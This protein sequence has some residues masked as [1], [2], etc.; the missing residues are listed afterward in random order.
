[1]LTTTENRLAGDGG[2]RVAESGETTLSLDGKQVTVASAEI[3]SGPR[4]QL[5]WSFYIVDGKITARLIEAKLLQARAVLLRR[6]PV[7][8]L[9]AF[10]AS[11]NDPGDPAEGQLARFL[12]AS[13]SLPR[14]VDSL[15]S[16]KT[17]PGV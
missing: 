6:A 3:V 4:R 9:V 11:M 8:A 5:V 15:R 17:E 13:Q 14:Y 1:M 7:A 2:W 12:A 16:A 10:S